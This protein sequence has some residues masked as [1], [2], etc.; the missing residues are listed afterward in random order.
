MFGKKLV[1]EEQN[2]S[3]LNLTQLYLRILLEKKDFDGALSFLEER[4]AN[5]PIKIELARKKLEIL[6][7]QE[8]KDG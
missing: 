6:R 7:C 1:N 3:D 8:D 4:K 2:K 5:F